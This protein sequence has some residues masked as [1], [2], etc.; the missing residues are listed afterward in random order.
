MAAS[1]L[2]HSLSSMQF[3]QTTAYIASFFL[4]PGN[5]RRFSQ[6]ESCHQNRKFCLPEVKK[7]LW[8]R[9]GTVIRI[10]CKFCVS[11]DQAYTEFP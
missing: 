10:V 4:F 6:L 3:G 9:I 1:S 5:H 11:I 8:H 7:E 2:E